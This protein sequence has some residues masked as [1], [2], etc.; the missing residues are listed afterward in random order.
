MIAK[1]RKHWECLVHKTLK[2]NI[3]ATHSISHQEYPN[4]KYFSLFINRV[5]KVLKDLN[6]NSILVL[7]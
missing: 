5:Y 7:C 6:P 4:G 1:L 3:Y 2:M